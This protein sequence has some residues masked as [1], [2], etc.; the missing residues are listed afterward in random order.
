MLPELKEI[1]SIDKLREGQLYLVKYEYRG[2]KTGYFK[3]IDQTRKMW[4]NW[5]FYAPELLT[6]VRNNDNDN[7]TVSNIN[8]I[9]DI[10]EMVGC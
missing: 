9:T 8:N 7:K 6:I 4:K 2:W 1:D 10:Y 3:L 5:F